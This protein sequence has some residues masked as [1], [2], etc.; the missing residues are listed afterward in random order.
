MPDAALHVLLVEDDDAYAAL[1]AAELAAIGSPL[2]LE[3]VTTLHDAEQRLPLSGFDAILLDLGLPDSEGLA[4][5]DRMHAA[6]PAVPMVIVTAHQDDDLA[7]QAVQR[8]ADDYLVKDEINARVVTRCIRYARERSGLR[9][10]LREREEQLRQ[11]QKMEAVGR[12]AGGIAHDFNNVLTAI[13]GYAD[14]LLD[15]FEEG[16]PRRADVE[17]I[18]QSA[19]RA[20]TLTRQLLAFSRRQIMLPRTI[21]LHEVAK[22][23]ENMLG[24]LVSSD[25]IIEIASE[26][27]L[28]PVRADPGQVEQ[29][30][31]NLAANARDAMPA[32]GRLTIETS[33]VRIDTEDSR[34]RPGLKPGDYVCLRVT[35]TGGGIPPDALAHIFEPFYTTKGLGKGT[36][37]GLATVYGI[38][39][40]MR[41]GIYVESTGP[42]GT[43]FAVFL[44]RVPAPDATSA[45]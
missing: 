32:G 20:A 42:S 22:G 28:W 31:M 26:V 4:T 15:Q 45:P 39:K 8:G 9:R 44:P 5:V 41:G 21:D 3:R 35:D 29:V 2:R 19:N 30:L 17:E 24:R 23:I 27:G 11:A 12:L 36:G 1:L 14:L 13:I 18:R 6:A 34:E 33:N 10:T 25:V 38:V 16:D 40:Q 43:R 7:F 37:L